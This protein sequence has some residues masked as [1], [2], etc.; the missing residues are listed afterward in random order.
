MPT[1][2]IVRINA[3]AM[4]ASTTPGVKCS[5]DKVDTNVAALGKKRSIWDDNDAY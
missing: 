4:I 2:D 1:M 5:K 3:E